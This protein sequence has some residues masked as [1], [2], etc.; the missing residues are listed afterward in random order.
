VVEGEGVA[1]LDR[2][3]PLDVSG[4]SHFTSSL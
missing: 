2:G 4:W 3:R 1:V